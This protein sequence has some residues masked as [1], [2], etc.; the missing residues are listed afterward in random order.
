MCY[1]A[2]MKERYAFRYNEF[3]QQQKEAGKLF[4]LE[5][6]SDALLSDV[7][8]RFQ[9][10]EFENGES[11]FF[12]LGVHVNGNLNFK[13]DLN[14]L[15]DTYGADALRIAL[16][17][18]MSLTDQNLTGCWRF[19]GN[20]WRLLKTMRLHQELSDFK[21]YESIQKKDYGQTLIDLKSAIKQENIGKDIFKL[22]YPFMPHLILSF[23]QDIH[24]QMPI[25]Y[26][27]IQTMTLP[28]KMFVQVNGKRVLDFYTRLEEKQ[29][30]ID[31]VLSFDKIKSK[32]KGKSVKRIIFIPKK[33]VNIVV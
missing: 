2:T 33:G 4:S 1:G 10:K 23:E 31:E 25:F 18:N 14:F 29:E 19:I 8:F 32:I 22:S 15:A 7:D 26:K 11:P 27:S 30:I 21:V 3:I 24:E 6:F 9:G 20:F 28:N 13:G 12:K 16:I 17:E 5:S